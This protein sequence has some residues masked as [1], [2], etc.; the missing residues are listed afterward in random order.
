MR[1]RWLARRFVR[2]GRIPGSLGYGQYKAIELSR[3]T[4]DP[5]LLER[6]RDTSTLPPGYGTGLDERIV[7]Y[8]WALVRIPSGRGIILDAGST[9]NYGWIAQLPTVKNKLIVVQTLAPEGTLETPNYSYVY[10]DL[11][12]TIFRDELFDT[13]V[14]LS[15]LEHVGLDNTRFYTADAAFREAEAE[16]FREVICEFNRVL[17]PGGRLLFSVPFGRYQNLG[18]L[19]QFDAALL[20]RAVEPF[21]GIV[22]EVTY[23]HCGPDGWQRSSESACENAEYRFR[24]AEFGVGGIATATAV[25][26]VCMER[27]AEVRPRV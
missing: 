5:D 25:A 11:R 19:Q 10:G 23:Y 14:C 9:L 1:D 8:P 3:V 2:Q 13:I 15:T 22:R 18:W 12:H 24:P 21:A 4:A 17:R 20:R 6:F 16:G 26:C 7:E 27:T